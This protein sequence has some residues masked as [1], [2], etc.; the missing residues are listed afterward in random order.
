[1]SLASL[2]VKGAS[3]A[4]GYGKRI[5]KVAP[6]FLL[7]ETSDV[8]G[9]A[10]RHTKG[11]LFTKGKA[12]FHALEK[13]VARQSK[14]G[15]F[16]TRVV[17]NLKTTPS[18]LKN[19]YKTAAATAKAAG[20]SG[21]I[22]G[23]KGAGKALLKKMPLIGAVLTIGL[24][25][26][27]IVKAFKDGGFK[28]GMKEIGGA[29]VELGCMAGGAAIGSA[30][31]PGIGT[32]IG[33]VVGGI[34][35]MF[36]RGK[37]HSE[38]KAEEEAL[39]QQ[40]AQLPQYSENDVKN[41]KE[42]GFTDDEIAQLQ[43]A[44]YT[45]EDIQAAIEQEMKAMEQELQKDPTQAL[46]PEQAYGSAQAYN[47]VQPNEQQLLNYDPVQAYAIAYAQ[48]QNPAYDPT[49]AYQYENI[50]VTQPLGFNNPNNSAYMNTNLGGK[51]AND[52]FF[53]KL[54]GTPTSSINPFN[55]YINNQYQYYA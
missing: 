17:R 41:L 1:M 31:C 23:A 37:T 38:K 55:D 52:I 44:G 12:G 33:A 45:M 47:S 46:E 19:G 54:F 21:V 24:E 29:G 9:G 48:S 4:L 6:D 14:N 25:V 11:S 15:S 50:S 27:N 28:A 26:P 32:A 13:H 7:G 53:Q 42:Y 16:F 43:Q 34:V 49:Q 22:A 39:A 36:A 20:K 30:I 5:A 8:V 40:Q 10:M 2:L 3:K 51:Y 35:G 18:A